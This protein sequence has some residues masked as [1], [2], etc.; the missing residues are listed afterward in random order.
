[1]HCRV[2]EI[3]RVVKI[4]SGFDAGLQGVGISRHRMPAPFAVGASVTTC[5]C[6]K[7]EEFCETSLWF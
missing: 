3:C 5:L 4:F 2:A 7:L 1:M 6:T